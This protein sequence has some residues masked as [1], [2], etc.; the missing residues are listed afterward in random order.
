[1]DVPSGCYKTST[2]DEANHFYNKQESC[3]EYY[4]C[5]SCTL[6]AGCYV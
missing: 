1:M 4:N 3:E 5:Y 2:C 6:S